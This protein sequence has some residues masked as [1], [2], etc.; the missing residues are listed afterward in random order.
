MSKIFTRT[1]RV[2]WGEL[3]PS[4]TVGPANYL[5]YLS[6]TAWDWGEAIGL[7]VS[8][9]ETLGMFWVIRETELRF[10]HPLRHN[11]VF[12]L[13]I[14]LA[15]WQRVRG[16]RCFE[17]KLKASGEVIA[18]GTQQVVCMDTKTGRPV[19]LTEDVID[20][21]RL[22][23]PPVFP[24]ERFPKITA[25]VNPFVM[26]RQVESMDLD[27]YDHVNNAIYLDYATEATAQDFSV[28]GWSPAK[29]AAANLSKSSKL[30]RLETEGQVKSDLSF[31]NTGPDQI[32][33][34]I[35]MDLKDTK[36]IDPNYKEIVVLFNARPNPVKFTDPAFMGKHFELHSVQQNS[37]DEIVQA[38]KYDSA[39]GAFALS[40]RTTAVFNIL[41]EPAVQATPTATEALPAIADP[42]VILTL[43]GV[44]GALIAVVVMMFALRR[45]DN[46]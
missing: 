39:N 31:Y 38:S 22:E 1:F 12:G 13:T 15:N 26:Q 29:L 33:G 4:G 28:R 35:V 42:G 34:L 25:P 7:G 32:P 43:A 40:G 23:D 24:S 37:S 21:F 45:K 20:R 6:E 27:V 18:Q 8:D 2:R 16:T 3:D 19:S 11:D 5:R 36:N 14:W 41:R 9:S 46:K 10:L 44:I 17:L 30:F